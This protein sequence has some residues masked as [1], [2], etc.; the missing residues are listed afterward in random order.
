MALEVD[1]RRRPWRRL[2]VFSVVT[3]FREV[4]TAVVTCEGLVVGFGTTANDHYEG[5]LELCRRAGPMV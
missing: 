2:G 1:T 3:A 4:I 5:L